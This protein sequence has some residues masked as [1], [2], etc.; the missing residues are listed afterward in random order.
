MTGERSQTIAEAVEVLR[1]GGLVVHPTST[2]YGIGGPATE[3]A[4]AEIARLKRRP[5]GM[6]LIR[7]APSI[8]VLRSEC[9]SLEWDERADRLAAAFWPGSLTIVLG[10][11]TASGLA[12]RIDSHPMVAELLDRWG[13]LL[14]STSLNAHGAEPCRT[15][16]A[17]REALAGLPDSD[18]PIAFV[19]A[20]ALPESASST[21]VSLRDRPARVLRQGAVAVADLR[22]CIEE[23]RVG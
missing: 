5:A 16:A 12:V 7:L 22:R 6:P 20:G 13:S 10:D 14:S 18:L 3:S 15:P 2:V 19:D 11:G 4:D 8:G 23:V 17:V 21:V 9:P 1:S